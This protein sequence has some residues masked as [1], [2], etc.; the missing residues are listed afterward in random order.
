[1]I[2]IGC[3]VE[4]FE[5][6]GL[7]ARLCCRRYLTPYFGYIFLPHVDW[8]AQCLAQRK[9]EKKYT[10]RKDKNISS[11]LSFIYWVKGLTDST[12]KDVGVVPKTPDSK[13]VL[14]LRRTLPESSRILCSLFQEENLFSFTHS[15]SPFPL[16]T[17]GSFFKFNS[18]LFIYL[19]IFFKSNFLFIYSFPIRFSLVCF[20]G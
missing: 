4:G 12:S 19:F 11:T 17:S 5:G 14:L 6:Q 1:M 16:R 2:I 7:R 9:S 10:K 3:G 8:P 20:L 15:S 18:F 13:M